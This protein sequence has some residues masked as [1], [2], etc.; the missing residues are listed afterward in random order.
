MGTTRFSRLGFMLV[1]NIAL[2][3]LC[4]T[5]I[6]QD[7][8]DLLLQRIEEQDRQIEAL[9]RE[10]N[11]LRAETAPP[12][13]QEKEDFSTREE[14]GR[15]AEDSEAPLTDYR[16]PGIRLDVAGQINQAINFAGDGDDT[17]AY[18]VDNEASNTRIRFSGVSGWEKGWKVGTTLE[19]ALSPN[20][21]TRVS[22]DNES[23]GDNIQVRRAEL[24]VLDER[25]GRLMFGQ[26]S[27]AADD[28]AEYDLSLVG[29]PIMYSGVSDIAGGLQFTDGQNLT[30]VTVLDAFFNFD[31]LRMNRIRYDSPMLG[32]AQLSLSAGSDQRYDAALTFGGDYG[33][34]SGIDLGPF[35]GLGAVSIH[36]PKDDDE[37]YR[38]AGSWSLLHDETGVSLTL[39]GGFDADTQGDTPYNL[40][41]K[42]GWDV[43]WLP[44]GATG[45]GLDYTFTENV[46]ADGDQG[47]S[48][49]LAA[50]QLLDR[51]G[52]ELYGQFRWYTLD[53][54]LGPD[55]DDILVGTLGTRVRF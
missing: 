25:Y 54:D 39:S 19:V 47:Q 1:L 16:Y 7:R 38:V 37:D 43:A 27:A 28:A 6:A 55:F 51:Y 24:F 44:F 34:W 46:S 12:P 15:Q 48:V 31:S 50:V 10:V 22:Q 18:F 23:A 14:W 45:F 30:G 8:I 42:L 53:R 2:S 36:D 33:Q 32:P 9:R 11:E 40:Y 13:K 35:T 52:I 5:A 29:G 26:G 17:K 20:P 21:S 3:T 41:G 4:G 49:G